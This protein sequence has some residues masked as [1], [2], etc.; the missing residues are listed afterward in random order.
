MIWIIISVIAIICLILLILALIEPHRPEFTHIKMTDDATPGLSLLFF[1]DIH[2]EMCYV[3]ADYICSLIEKFK[4]GAVAFGGD[5]ATY[6]DKRDEGYQYL[7]QIAVCCKQHNIPF[8][9]VP[10]NHDNDLTEEDLANGEFINLAG[11][12]EVLG[13]FAIS[14]ISDSGRE[15]RVWYEPVEVPEGKKHILL[16]HDP[17]ALLHFADPDKIDYML[18]GHF[19]GGQIRTHLKLEFAIREDELPHQG[20]ICGKHRIGRTE[21]YISRGLGCAWLP[22]RLGVRPEVSLIE[23]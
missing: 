15:E 17:D 16:A 2:A 3:K 11:R 12:Y 6:P 10:G 19:H 13:D 8:Y 22:I 18:S 5:I 23:F 1:S 21:V 14:G 20:I 7:R 9:G 4:P